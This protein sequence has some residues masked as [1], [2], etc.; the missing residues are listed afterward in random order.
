MFHCAE[1]SKSPAYMPYIALFF[2]K[3][4]NSLQTKNSRNTSRLCSTVH[5]T[6]DSFYGYWGQQISSIFILPIDSHADPT[7]GLCANVVCFPLFII[8]YRLNETTK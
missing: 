2:K 5:A 3:E 4:E 7:V 6:T 8:R 1:L